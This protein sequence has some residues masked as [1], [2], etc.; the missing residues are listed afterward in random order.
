MGVAGDDILTN[1]KTGQYYGDSISYSG[2]RSEKIL[3]AFEAI[4]SDEQY[5]PEGYIEVQPDKTTYFGWVIQE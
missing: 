3:Y 4:F 2:L 5:N 1:V